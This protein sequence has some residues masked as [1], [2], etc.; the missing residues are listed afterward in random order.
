M[1]IAHIYQ[2]L[3]YRALYCIPIIIGALWEAAGYAVRAYANQNQDSVAVYATQSI[4]IVLAPACKILPRPVL[5]TP[6]R[7]SLCT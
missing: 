6:G 7:S 3:R 1:T 5:L 2:F 4:L